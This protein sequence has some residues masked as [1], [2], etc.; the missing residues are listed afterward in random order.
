MDSR[1][2]RLRS[3]RH[4]LSDRG[5]R[6]KEARC[7]NGRHPLPKPSDSKQ[8]Q[9]LEVGVVHKGQDLDS[10]TGGRERPRTKLEQVRSLSASLRNEQPTTSP[11]CQMR[12]Q[13][14]ANNGTDPRV[15]KSCRDA[16]LQSSSGIRPIELL[17][18]TTIDSIQETLP[19]T[20]TLTRG[21]RT[22]K[23]KN[24]V[25]ETIRRNRHSCQSGECQ[26]EA[27]SRRTPISGKTS[28][29]KDSEETDQSKLQRWETKDGQCRLEPPSPRFGR[30]QE[31]KQQNHDE[32]AR[33]GKKTI[34]TYLKKDQR[35]KNLTWQTDL[36]IESSDDS[37][38]ADDDADLTDYENI[39]ESA[40]QQTAISA[41]S[42]GGSKLKS[43]GGFATSEGIDAFGSDVKNHLIACATAAITANF[44]AAHKAGLR[45]AECGGHEWLPDGRDSYQPQEPAP[46][47]HH[48]AGAHSV[49]SGTPHMSMDQ[50][51]SLHLS[52]D[53]IKTLVV[54]NL[55]ATLIGVYIL[56]S[57]AV[58][59][60]LILPYLF[61]VPR[62]M[63]AHDAAASDLIS[64]AYKR[65]QKQIMDLESRPN[66]GSSP[67]NQHEFEVQ[68]NLKMDDDDYDKSTKRETNL[69]DT[70]RHHDEHS[71]VSTQQLVAIQQ[72]PPKQNEK[73]SDHVFDQKETLKNGAIDE[74]AVGVH[75]KWGDMW[76][77]EH[78]GS[79][80]PLQVP[81]CSRTLESMFT[82]DFNPPGQ[83]NLS[84]NLPPG[85][86]L[87]ESTL[88]PNRVIR[89]SQSN[90]QGILEKYEPIVGVKCFAL[91]RL[92]LCSNFAPK[93]V[94]IISATEPQSP[95]DHHITL[96]A[97]SNSDGPSRDNN[98][99]LGSKGSHSSPITFAG[100]I[101]VAKRKQQQQHRSRLVPPCRSLCKG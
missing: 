55:V 35:S 84:P 60:A 32:P 50:T 49:K 59:M 9:A 41:T 71:R 43:E 89:T 44:F 81:F 20:L 4:H 25:Q 7:A 94:P 92:F 74:E 73:R 70:A 95:I 79:C 100:P 56:I 58:I 66:A 5:S 65:A 37:V 36:V 75:Y 90:I 86:K 101:Q 18:R 77:A 21:E 19:W 42:S 96:G 11:R 31:N 93:C 16:H 45:D 64:D 57:L 51:H 76:R 53:K 1:E 82:M 78:N 88:L 8:E 17:A 40:T 26:T 69:V 28:T 39:F 61:N 63:D 29:C 3:C 46:P 87:Y 38:S 2:R 52:I 54:R 72:S 14:L 48:R 83:Q 34:T 12:V 13:A 6:R 98:S 22:H 67:A 99:A 91:M 80:E 97:T 33:S 10:G 23:F 68:S 27:S 24:V 62:G 85:P 30:G 47:Y 15:N